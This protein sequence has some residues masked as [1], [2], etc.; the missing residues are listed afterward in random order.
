LGPGVG[1]FRLS[2]HR[3]LW[4]RSP[5][6]L[7]TDSHQFSSWHTQTHIIWASLQI[8]QWPKQ[9]LEAN[10]TQLNIF[11]ECFWCLFHFCL[12]FGAPLS[13]SQRTL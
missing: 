12:E 8:G 11:K 13:H 3:H 4:T 10:S 5:F 1:E 2:F 7:Y 6:S 9:A